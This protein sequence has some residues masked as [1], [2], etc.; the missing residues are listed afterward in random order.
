MNFVKN[1]EILRIVSDANEH[2]FSKKVLSHPH[3]VDGPV[4]EIFSHIR[5]TTS[6][7]MV[8]PVFDWHISHLTCR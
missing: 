4:G 1:T 7:E 2:Y 8:L 6:E 3:G 5:D